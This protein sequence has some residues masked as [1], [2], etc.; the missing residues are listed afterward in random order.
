MWSSRCDL[1]FWQTKGLDP[2]M[3]AV[4]DQAIQDFMKNLTCNIGN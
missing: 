1:Y 3:F 2:T 4:V